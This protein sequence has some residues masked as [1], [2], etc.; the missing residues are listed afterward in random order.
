[1]TLPNDPMMLLSVINMNLRDRNISFKELC[2]SEGLDAEAIQSKLASIDYY[3]E[4]T[5]GQFR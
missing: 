2:A 4:A 3:Y 1:M 5:C